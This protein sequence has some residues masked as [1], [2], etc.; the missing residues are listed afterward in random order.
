[1]AGIEA[2]TRN[3]NVVLASV[4]IPLLLMTFF[5]LVRRRVGNSVTAMP[6]VL[7]FLVVID[8][9][10]ASQPDPWVR[11]VN[12]SLAGFFQAL[13]ISLGLLAAIVFIFSLT[14][15][16]RLIRFWVKRTFPQ[17]IHLMP[18][19][20][21]HERFPYLGVMGSWFLIACIVGLNALPFAQR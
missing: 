20:I 4:I 11:I 2:L 14:V 19:D 18:P 9:Y 10:F 1:M 17:T 16:R 21:A 12:Q 8:F 15:E 13:F 5:T 3:A 6:D 7:V